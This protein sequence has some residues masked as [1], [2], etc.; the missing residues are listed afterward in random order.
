[1]WNFTNF[2]KDQEDQH[3]R[4]RRDVTR[5]IECSLKSL[6]G[7]ILITANDIG[8]STCYEYTFLGYTVS[9]DDYFP[10]IKSYKDVQCSKLFIGYGVTFTE[11]ARAKRLRQ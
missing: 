11:E 9:S 1:M 6:I 2:K 5:N 3:Y 7:I 10:E 4:T 8:R